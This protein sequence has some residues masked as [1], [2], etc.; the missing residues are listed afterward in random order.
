MA[1]SAEVFSP[2][3]K[4]N[5]QIPAGNYGTLAAHWRDVLEIALVL[6]FI[7]AA[8]WTPQ[9]RVNALFSLTAAACVVAFA[10]VGRWSSAEMGLTKPFAG[11][12]SI[13]LLGA[14]SCGAIAAIGYSLRPVGSGYG[15]P[16]DRSWQ[17]A[18]WSLIQ[19]FILQAIFFLR[20]EAVFGSRRAVIAAAALFALVHIPSPVLTILAFI[21]GILF[22]ECFRRWRNLYPIGV[23][24]A[25]LGLTIAAHMP[26]R[27]LHH[28][29]VGIGYL[30]MHS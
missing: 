9:G 14:L 6:A 4:T 5:T 3:Q 28:M 16:W 27:W 2:I 15:L 19:E 1:D 24:H 18:L 10:V 17:Y 23:I 21:G 7:F 20:L 30:A 22:C 26:D 8:V 12:G 29:R 13:L 25:A 11:G